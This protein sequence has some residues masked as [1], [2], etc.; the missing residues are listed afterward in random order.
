M[1]A[2][3]ILATSA[4]PQYLQIAG[5]RQRLLTNIR[6]VQGRIAQKQV[7]QVTVQLFKDSCAE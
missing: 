3:D 5:P 4:L 2:R 1:G 7:L 6:T